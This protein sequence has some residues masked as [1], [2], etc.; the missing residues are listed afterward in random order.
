MERNP[1][2]SSEWSDAS[3]NLFFN[4]HEFP[5]I[6][7]ALL[8]LS[9]E[10]LF[11]SLL[12]RMILF[13]CFAVEEHGE[14]RHH[15]QTCCTLVRLIDCSTDYLIVIVISREGGSDS[16]TSEP[17]VIPTIVGFKSRLEWG[18]EYPSLSSLPCEYHDTLLEKCW[19]TRWSSINCSLGNI[20]S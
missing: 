10:L 20:I 11:Q 4:E 12:M 7:V 8:L 1:H 15:S 16:G 5:R 6:V 19:S 17:S 18:S 13:R 14:D 9:L 3:H 2:R